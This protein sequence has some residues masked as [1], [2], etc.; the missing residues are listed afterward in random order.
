MAPGIN[1]L[2]TWILIAALGGLFVLVGQWIGGTNGA[3][4]A[5]AIA[6]VFN[7]SMY[8][9]SD[10]IAIATTRSKPVTEREMPDYYRIVRQLTNE[11]QLPMP[12]LFVSEMM[13]PNAFATGRNPEH[14]SVAV[15]RG[16]LQILDERELRAVLAHELSHVANRDILI[17][18][19]AA[20]IG[21]SITFL[22]RFAL[23]FGGGDDNRGGG[24]AF[25]LLAAWLL[26][27]IAAALIQMAVSRSR[28]YQ[29]DESGAFLSKDP[30]ALAGALRKL[31]QASRQVPAP[32][33]VS[34][35]EAHLFIVNPMNAL[36]ARG[37]GGFVNLFST[38]PPTEA[39]IERLEAIARELRG[40]RGPI[41]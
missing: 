30:D 21:M 1:R 15:T 6:L 8:W 31:E 33:T 18:S 5:L 16:I 3:V 28:E 20:A 25:A 11:R 14:A 29:A 13:Q 32:A 10:K 34:P 35:A 12:K 38:H 9:F 36:K 4:I 22:A 7:F 26:A 37:G 23:F 24:N 19:I 39:R 2:K 27:P 17:S 40:E 41:G